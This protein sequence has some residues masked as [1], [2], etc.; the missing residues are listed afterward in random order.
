MDP[1]LKRLCAE[2]V[3]WEVS[4]GVDN[5]GEPVSSTSNYSIKARVT[6]NT[7]FTFEREGQQVL[8]AKTIICYGTSSAMPVEA[9]VWL[10]GEST[11]A[12]PWQI[13][14]VQVAINE[15]GSTD[16]FRILL[17]GRG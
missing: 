15:Q 8:A 9:R 2:T 17:Q 16:Y 1:A 10:P 6:G 3:V 11:S 5:Y 4:T 13:G 12:Q 7:K 14:A